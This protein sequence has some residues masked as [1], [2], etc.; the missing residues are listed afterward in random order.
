MLLWGRPN[1]VGA[2]A[3]KREVQ[4]YFAVA[5]M[6]K[7]DAAGAPIW[8]PRYFAGLDDD[9]RPRFVSEQSEAVAL[10]SI[11]RRRRSTRTGRPHQPDEP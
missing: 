5:D 9:D 7:L 11:G 10:E 2:Q 4:L 6:P 8:S 1:Y 3:R